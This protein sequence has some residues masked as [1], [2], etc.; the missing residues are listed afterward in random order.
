[1]AANIKYPL[2]MNT[3]TSKLFVHTHACTAEPIQTETHKPIYAR[4]Q[5]TSEQSV[6]RVCICMMGS[7]KIVLETFILRTYTYSVCVCV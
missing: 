4:I 6:Q 1:M 3:T 2:D 5:F 7:H